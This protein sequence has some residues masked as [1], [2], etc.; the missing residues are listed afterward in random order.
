VAQ[1]PPPVMGSTVWA[2]VGLPAEEETV[3]A[4]ADE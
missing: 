4:A 3:W 1:A 2:V